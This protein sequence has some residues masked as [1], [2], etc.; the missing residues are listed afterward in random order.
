MKIY[1]NKLKILLKYKYII[2]LLFI[3]L[4][5]L[6]RSN[7]TYTSK[8]NIKDSL[9][10]GYVI[11]YKYT[12]NKLTFILK[13]KELIRCN[14]Y[15]KDNNKIDINY[16]DY[17]SVTGKLSIPNNNTIPNTFNYKKSKQ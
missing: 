2:I 14:Y 5:S 4:I 11:D 10:S 3:V 16:N 13:G 1:L 7:I 17:I 6:Y 12:D 8:Y 9:F 15:I